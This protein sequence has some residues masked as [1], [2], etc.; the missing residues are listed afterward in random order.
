MH[1]LAARYPGYGWDKNVGYGTRRHLQGIR[2]RGLTPFHRLSFAPV[3][4]FLLQPT[5]LDDLLGG[6]EA[7]EATPALA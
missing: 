3:R 2:E 7:L 5:S 4:T 1:T 6:L